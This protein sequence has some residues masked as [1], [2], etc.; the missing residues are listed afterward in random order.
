MLEQQLT[1]WQ[2][3]TTT[4]I[5]LGGYRS[6]PSGK[7]LLHFIH[8]NGFCSMMYAPL[9]HLLL[10]YV[11]VFLSDVQGHGQSD[12][13]GQF[14]GWDE[15]ATA[16]AQAFQHFAA[17]YADVT[18]IGCGHSFGG[19]VTAL[20]AASDSPFQQLLL[21]D[22]VIFTPWMHRSAKVLQLFGLYKKNPLVKQAHRR[23]Q[24]WPS[25]Q[26]AWDYFYQRGIFKGWHDDALTAYL[27]HALETKSD[28]LALR[29]HPSREAEIFGSVPRRLWRQLQQ[30]SLPTQ[31]L[32][33][34]DTYP[35]V[36]R[37]L[38]LWQQ[39]H[40][41]FSTVQMPG[42]H[43]FM[44]QHPAHTADYMLQRLRATKVL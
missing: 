6:I 43:C 39:Q 24:H 21:L 1:P 14:I 44:Q 19:V 23:R 26:A 30:I 15:S 25:R 3:T 32:F 20:W 37:S 42:D 29:C 7:P 12:H 4:G 11:D 33:G 16:A 41:N 22:P 34:Q 31:V 38:T 13:G 27:D 9:W 10:P 36:H 40:P 2:F 18:K 17:E 28:G 8:G 35:F 5:R